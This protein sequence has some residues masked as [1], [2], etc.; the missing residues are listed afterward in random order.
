M[1]NFTEIYLQGLKATETYV[2]SL[3]ERAEKAEA[4]NLKLYAVRQQERAEHTK[5]VFKLNEEI[6]INSQGSLKQEVDRLKRERDD[7]CDAYFRLKDGMRELLGE[8]PLPERKRGRPHK[9][10]Y[11]SLLHER[12]RQQQT[13]PVIPIVED[14]QNKSNP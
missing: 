6:R 5:A 3:I 7:A 9:R 2:Q 10:T 12:D 13:T 8:G 1:D 4:L 14:E 11:T